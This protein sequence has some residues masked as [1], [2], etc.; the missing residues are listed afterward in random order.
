MRHTLNQSFFSTWTPEMA[1][2]LGFFAADGSML[3]NSRGGCFIEFTGADKNILVLIQK[4]IGSNHRLS[5]R[6]RTIKGSAVYR[7]QIGSKQIFS[8]LL[9]L[10]FTQAKSK[11]LRMPTIPARLQG[12]FIRGY[13]D[14]DGCIYFKKLQFAD[15]K[16]PR[17]VLQT[18]FTCGNKDFLVEL[19][20]LLHH[21]GIAGGS[22]RN[23]TRGFDLLLSHK[24]SVALYRLMYH[25]V[26]AT[27]LYLPRKYKHFQK[28]IKALYPYWGRSSTG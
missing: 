7:F 19:R 1:Y 2:V 22:I 20:S 4:T 23:K 3:L 8:D 26:S 21:R 28:A 10:G 25:T 6:I 17:L 18:I 13:F 12:D 5:K 16:K 24:D 9:A 11:T 15:R 14:G 27:G